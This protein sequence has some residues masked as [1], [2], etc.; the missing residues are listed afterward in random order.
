MEENQKSSLKDKFD[1][2]YRLL[3]RR[4]LRSID[5]EDPVLLII[6]Q[7]LGMQYFIKFQQLSAH[8]YARILQ[9]FNN[10]GLPMETQFQERYGCFMQLIKTK[11]VFSP[12]EF[13][14]QKGMRI[15]RILEI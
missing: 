12:T 8:W 11:L 9:F 7:F 1:S 10:F 15:D 2:I 6:F 3:P 5:F 4:P 14:N 13:G